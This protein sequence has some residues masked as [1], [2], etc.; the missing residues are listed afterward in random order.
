MNNDKPKWPYHWGGKNRHLETCSLITFSGSAPMEEKDCTCGLYE[1]KNPD[2]PS[3]EE[4]NK[5]TD[6]PMTKEQFR[7]FLKEA[8]L[9]GVD[10]GSKIAS[11]SITKKVED[12]LQAQQAEIEELKANPVILASEIELRTEMK[13]LER[14]NQALQARIEELEGEK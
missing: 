9:K 3:V 10:E 13:S 7:A 2:Q 11:R 12:R 4:M 5:D 8:Y 1:F 6:Q 14:Q